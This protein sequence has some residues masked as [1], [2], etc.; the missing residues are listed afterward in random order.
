MTRL[1]CVLVVTSAMLAAGTSSPAAKM[2]P[3]IKK[4]VSKG[5]E[6]LAKSQ[7]PKQGYWEANGGSTASP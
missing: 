3:K 5:L 7:R 2:D 4:A 6:W 1:F